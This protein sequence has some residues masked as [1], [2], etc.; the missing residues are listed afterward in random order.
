MTEQ[1][2][3]GQANG[4]GIAHDIPHW[5]DLCRQA[6][7]AHNTDAP[8]HADSADA[9]AQLEAALAQAQREQ[10]DQTPTLRLDT[11]GYITHWN[12]GAAALF[13]YSAAEAL[14]Q[15]VLFLYQ[16]EDDA[17]AELFLDQDSAQMEVR[18][19]KKSG[20][21]FR[22]TMRLELL[23]DAQGDPEGMLAQFQP[24][25][26]GLSNDDKLR[27]YLRII[28]DSNQG[29]MVSDAQERIVVVNT[30]FTRIT[31]YTASEALG[32]TPDLLRSGRHD[33]QFRAQVRQAMKG[34]HP[35]SGEIL[36]RRKN[37]EVFPQ[38]VSISAIRDDQG[39]I[40]HA[41]SI[42][43]D[44]TAHK[45]TEAQLHRLA[46]F[47]SVTGLPNRSLLLQLVGQALTGVQRHKS[48][49]ALLV[50]HLQR[51]AVLYDTLGHDACD[52]LLQEAS[53]RFRQMLREQDVLARTG[54]DK[55]AIALLDINKREHAA[56]VAQKL[57]STLDHNFRL[58]GH[59]LRLTAHI[60]V[61]IFPDDGLDTTTLL[62]FAELAAARARE[63]GDHSEAGE[64]L[65][66]SSEMNQRASA[67]FRIES[68][69]R[70][71]LARDEL[72]L[73][74]QPKVSLRSGRIAGAEGLLRWQH[75]EQGLLT[76]A[77]FVAV[78]EETRLILD[79]GDW[80]LEQAC[81][82]LRAWA[83]A[84]LLMPPVAVNLSAR[85]V[86]DRLP[87]LVERLLN[88]HGVKP[89][90]LK[91]EITE[92]LVMRNP[93]LVLPVL[94]QLVAMGLSIALDDFGTGYSSLAYL[95][96]FPITTLKIDRAFVIGVPH[97]P[98]DC[99]IAQAIVT[100]GKQMRQEIVAEGV[101][102][103]EQMA[104]LRDLGCDQLQG[105]L[106]SKPLTAEDYERWVREDVRLAL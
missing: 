94:N 23:R 81:R 97:E 54:N 51:V 43:S 45:A 2:H 101:E 73:F 47:D 68:E 32:K 36:G 46:N 72:R 102:T 40:T 22:A 84:G 19:R 106:F 52:A 64:C 60:G 62:R 26:D 10:Q 98:N 104:F 69:L 11:L 78:A 48:H 80:V 92:S 39:R 28:E 3:S 16:E 67:H 76:P 41:F 93:E 63:V 13:G 61:S 86:D 44:I 37:G 30:A 34:E 55:F 58:Q 24:L 27:L 42:F 15:H 4:S 9:L 89:S 57:L 71:A 14:G 99:A 59:E 53:Q 50:L 85:Q 6:R 7:Q 49:G 82:Q 87:E 91:L 100:M 90:Q 105:Y 96:R 79:L 103:R 29:V 12:A 33:A 21:V 83:D 56:I 66:Y 8:A 17:P 77:Q 88:R 31:G 25:P 5:L 18:R 95:K 75:P 65:F 38:S 74:Y 35:W 1:Q 20:E 70:Q